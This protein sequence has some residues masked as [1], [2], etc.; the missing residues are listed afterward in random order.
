MKFGVKWSFGAALLMLGGAFIYY[1][2]ITG[3]E[4]NGGTFSADP[5]TGMIYEAFGKWAAVGFWLLFAVVLVAAGF[6]ALSLKRSGQL[7]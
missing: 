7:E 1:D 2:D 5:F 6:R 4:E 3:V